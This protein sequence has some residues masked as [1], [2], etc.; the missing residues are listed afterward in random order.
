[1]TRDLSSHGLSPG[2]L[3]KAQA[4]RV[5][6]GTGPGDWTDERAWRARQGALL[7]EWR[8]GHRLTR[9]SLGDL[10]DATARTVENHEDGFTALP[11]R[12]RSPACCPRRA[13]R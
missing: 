12:R 9:A 6:N 11:T 5:Q 10:V 2:G 7:R 8:E 3:L 4:S 1:M 13:A